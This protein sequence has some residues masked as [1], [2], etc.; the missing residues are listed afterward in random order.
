MSST[1]INQEDLKT[2]LR[3]LIREEPGIIAEIIRDLA[4]EKASAAES[5][6]ERSARMRK[7]IQMDFDEFEET[8]K[9]LA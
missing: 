9:A 8:F 5:A 3:E 6:E 4:N 1:T 7:L 2:A